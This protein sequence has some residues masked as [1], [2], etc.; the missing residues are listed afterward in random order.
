MCYEKSLYCVKVTE[1]LK[2]DAVIYIIQFLNT[3]DAY[4]IYC[5]ECYITSQQQRCL[6][7]RRLKDAVEISF[8]SRSRTP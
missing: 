3:N 5:G 6:Q 4:K 7:V 1:Y 8:K 2:L